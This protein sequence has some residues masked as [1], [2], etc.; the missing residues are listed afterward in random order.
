ME[1]SCYYKQDHEKQRD[2]D[3]RKGRVKVYRS[4]GEGE[5]FLISVVLPVIKGYKH[6]LDGD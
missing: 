3:G 4:E 6:I 2:G 5:G 1:I